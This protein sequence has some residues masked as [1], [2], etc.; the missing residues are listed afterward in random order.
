MIR[1]PVGAEKGHGTRQRMGRA[2][3]GNAA[4]PEDPDTRDRKGHM[5]RRFVTAT[6]AR[7]NGCHGIHRSRKEAC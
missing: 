3:S 7:Q 5:A 4:G 6:T 1:V 2:E